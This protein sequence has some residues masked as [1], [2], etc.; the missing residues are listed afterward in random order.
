MK[1]K[2]YNGDRI[3]KTDANIIFSFGSRGSGKTYFWK[4]YLLNHFKKTGRKFF[5][6]R[7]YIEELKVLKDTFFD[8][9]PNNG[10][11]IKGFDI[12]IDDKH[13]GKYISLSQY[14][15]YKSVN[16]SMYDYLMFDEILPDDGKYLNKNNYT[17]EPEVLLNW[18]QSIARG[19]DTPIRTDV[20]FICIS[21]TI[22]TFNPYSCF[23]KFDKKLVAGATFI[24]LKFVCV[25]VYENKEV[26]KDIL[27]S[28]YGQ[29]IKDTEYGQYALYN[30]FYQDKNGLLIDY[31]VNKKYRYIT[32]KMDNKYYTLFKQKNNDLVLVKTNAD[33]NH[34]KVFNVYQGEPEP[35]IIV[36]V[37]YKILKKYY[38]V[39][40]LKA[41]NQETGEIL[42]LLFE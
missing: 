13:C 23:Y 16:M 18:Y 38:N 11:S 9:I 34:L 36:D 28:A 35:Y 24:N 27:E 14:T 10:V 17:Y 40:R 7:R 25:E 12:Y 8:D 31:N 32:L 5:I 29:F 39:S 6:M 3:L 33:F 42:R 21:N 20:R 4:S 22:K 30:K 37:T 15:K 41:I 26:N 2:F 19:Y 1:T